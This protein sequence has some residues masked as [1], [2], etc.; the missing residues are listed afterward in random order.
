MLIYTF[1]LS[2]KMLKHETFEDTEA[3]VGVTL[4]NLK[5]KEW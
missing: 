3:Q 1:L 4:E 2:T 5:N